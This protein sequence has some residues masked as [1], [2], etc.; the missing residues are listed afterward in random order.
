MTKGRPK[1]GPIK[2]PATAPSAGRRASVPAGHGTTQ[3]KTQP[4]YKEIQYRFK[5]TMTDKY[6]N[7]FYDE[8]PTI[9]LLPNSPLTEEI[10]EELANT[11]STLNVFPFPPE[12]GIRGFIT[13]Q[14]N[15]FSV[16]VFDPRTETWRKL[17]TYTK[18]NHSMPGV[19]RE[20]VNDRVEWLQTTGRLEEMLS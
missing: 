8:L 19:M 7:R 12:N 18:N 3:Q 20:A 15:A 13:E 10:I 16:A 9:E 4:R 2:I 14:E 6:E 5:L 1:L 11:D 17:T